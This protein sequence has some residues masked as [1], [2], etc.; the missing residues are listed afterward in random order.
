MNI[1]LTM[2][3]VIILIAVI[4]FLDLK[5]LRKDFQKRLIINILIV[6]IFAVFY[7]LFLNNL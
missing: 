2:L 1:I 6:L 5:Y 4:V 7:A 3:Y